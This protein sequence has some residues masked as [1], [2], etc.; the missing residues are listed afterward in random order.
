MRKTTF[1]SVKKAHKTQKKKKKKKK[2]QKRE[3]F[4]VDGAF[5][6]TNVGPVLVSV[7]PFKRIAALLD[8]TP[9]RFEL[10]FAIDFI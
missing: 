6:Q 10:S 1:M 3:W 5:S 8:P 4:F 9:V 7:N 2:W